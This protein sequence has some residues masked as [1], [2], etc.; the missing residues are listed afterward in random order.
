M[1]FRCKQRT[2][3]LDFFYAELAPPFFFGDC[4]RSSWCYT[5]VWNEST[6]SPWD[7]SIQIGSLAQC[8]IRLWFSIDG[9][10]PIKLPV[11]YPLKH[12]DR[13]FNFSKL[14][15]DMGLFNRKLVIC[16]EQLAALWLLFWAD[17]KLK[18]CM[19]YV[20]H[21]SLQG[22][23]KEVHVHSLLLSLLVRDLC[24]AMRR[25]NSCQFYFRDG[26]K[27][28]LWHVQK[29]SFCSNCYIEIG[30]T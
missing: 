5:C 16:L 11:L 26:C 23:C 6:W 12:H 29:W 30:H 22:V 1:I 25:G 8:P 27:C 15:I 19:V 13:A 20:H 18:R 7:N 3:I 4:K 24:K 17:S 14:K 10:L 2:H 9:L 28:K 21:L